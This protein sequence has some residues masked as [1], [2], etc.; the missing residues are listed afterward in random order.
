MVNTPI[1]QIGDTMVI[2]PSQDLNES[3]FE[4]IETDANHA[5]KLLEETHAKNA[6]LDFRNTDYYG[7]TA[8]GF[9]VKLWKRVRE[10]GGSMALCNVSDHEREILNITKL[11]RLWPI[12]KTREEA[13][14]RVAN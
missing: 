7:S 14:R 3:A 11:D 6:V 13:M 9:F 1:E 4:Q 10:A 5:L 12:C 8:L 2:T